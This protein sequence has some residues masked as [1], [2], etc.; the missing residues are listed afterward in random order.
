MP[1]ANDRPL[2][3]PR[4]FFVTGMIVA[5]ALMRLAPHPYNFT[6][7]AAMALFGGANF[8][9]RRWGFIVP[10]TAMLV[11]DAL[12][13]AVKYEQYRDRIWTTTLL[14]Y[15]SF[16]LVACLG[17]WL[18]NHRKIRHIAAATLAGSAIFFVLT[19]FGAWAFFAM[20]P[21][22][23]EGLVAC[24]LAAIPFFENGAFGGPLLNTVL[25][26]ITYVT[27]L[28]GGLAL[29]ERSLSQLQEQPA[30]VRVR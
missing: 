5:A 22:T 12:L 30:A 23:L 13:Y 27:A 29:A 24:Y 7:M 2:L 16:A 28:F 18:R 17:L 20:Y 15:A 9:Q 25:G 8:A 4:V 6:P 26:D 1:T 3:H 19:N 11:S 14:V 10:L 21:K